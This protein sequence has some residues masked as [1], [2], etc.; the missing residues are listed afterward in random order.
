MVH[1][2]APLLLI[3]EIAL[4]TL[5]ACQPE[6]LAENAEA[7]PSLPPI[8]GDNFKRL[9]QL[10]TL[11]GDASQVNSLAFNPDRTLLAAAKGGYN[12]AYTDNNT[13]ELWSVQSGKLSAILPGHTLPV[14]SVAFSPDGSVLASGASHPDGASDDIVRLWDVAS[15]REL[16]VIEG[17]SLPTS[18]VTFSPYDSLLVFNDADL[19][20]WDTQEREPLDT[21]ETGGWYPSQVAISP[22]GKYLAAV[23]ADLHSQQRLQLWN[24]GTRT[25]V[26]ERVLTHL[27]DVAFGSGGDVLATA[28]VDYSEP[29][30]IVRLHNA[31]TLEV[32]SSLTVPAS[33]IYDITFSPDSSLLV[34]NA[35]GRSSGGGVWMWAHEADRSFSLPTSHDIRSIAFRPDGTLLAAGDAAGNIQLW[36]VSQNEVR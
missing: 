2:R 3:A 25:L 19:Q 12:D 29:S 24:L 32:I 1:A 35:H 22:D 23:I 6:P 31:E 13:I 16:L 14:T 10:A 21:L 36:S 34:L 27:I 30:V 15:G 8:T 4:I 9:E 26:R 7:L 17:H 11:Q 28:S 20:L 18:S 5:V 33:N